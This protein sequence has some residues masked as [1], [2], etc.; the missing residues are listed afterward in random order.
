MQRHG[1]PQPVQ[2]RRVQRSRSALLAAAVRL[3]VERE[4]TDIAVTDLTD[5]ADVSRK[6]LYLHFA[7]RD[8]LLVAAAADLVER[9]LLPQVDEPVDDLRAQV[10]VLAHHFAG[11]RV[12]YRAMLTGSC[13]FAMS[14]TLDD[15]FGS[16]NRIFVREQYAGLDE[17]TVRDLAAFF[18]GGASRLLSEWLVDDADPLRPEDLADRLLRVASVLM[19]PSPEPPGEHRP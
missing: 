5:A 10:L 3:V 1:S 17:P 8:G 11:H 16:L 19:P 2:D 18:I 12:F 4:T 15:L 7:D 6:V 9:E 14:R 13:A